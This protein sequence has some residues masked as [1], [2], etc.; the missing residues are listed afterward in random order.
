MKLNQVSNYLFKK[1]NI[2]CLIESIKE[3]TTKKQEK[4]AFLSVSDETGLIDLTV[5]PKV[6]QNFN[7]QIKDL[8]KVSGEVTKRFDKISI[9]VNNISKLES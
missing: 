3:I 6:Y 4:M 5:F 9:I 2:I 8:V 1:V 7:W